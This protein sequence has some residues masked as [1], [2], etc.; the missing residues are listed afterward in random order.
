MYL[1]FHHALQINNVIDTVIFP[2]ELVTYDIDYFFFSLFII[3]SFHNIF[4]SVT[5]EFFPKS[6]FLFPL[7]NLL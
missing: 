4:A 1:K 5:L 6:H 2:K 7:V 3:F